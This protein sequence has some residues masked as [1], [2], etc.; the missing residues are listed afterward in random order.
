LAENLK[1]NR[2][3]FTFLFFLIAGLATAVSAQEENRAGLVILLGDGSVVTRCVSFTESEISGME[4]LSR[5]DVDLVTADRRMGT[6]VCN[7][8]GEGCPANDCFCACQGGDCVYWSYW[9]Q[10]EGVWRYSNIGASQYTV[11]NGDVEGWVWGLGS[12]TEAP[13]PPPLTFDRD[14]R[15][16]NTGTDPRRGPFIRA[17]ATPAA[18]TAVPAP[19]NLPHPQPPISPVCSFSASSCWPGRFPLPAP[20]R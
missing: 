18:P 20:G 12:P 3:T 19:E 17:A 15:R 16:S 4:L 7:L 8:S 13:E 10:Q 9:H 14:L 11:E 1:L 5:A 2:Y 6:T